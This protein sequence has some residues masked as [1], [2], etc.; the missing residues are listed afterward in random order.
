MD[1]NLHLLEGQERLFQADFFFFL[2]NVAKLKFIRAGPSSGGCQWLNCFAVLI[3]R[4]HNANTKSNGNF[5]FSEMIITE[6]Q[7]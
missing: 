5:I 3:L 7:S 4:G 6:L 2:Q 1:A